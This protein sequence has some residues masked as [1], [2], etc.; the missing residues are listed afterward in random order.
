MD[1]IPVSS[2]DTVDRKVG[3][4]FKRAWLVRKWRDGHG[5]PKADDF[6]FERGFCPLVSEVVHPGDWIA[7]HKGELYLK[8]G[9]SEPSSEPPNHDGFDTR[10]IP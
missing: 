3:N 6:L 4:E 8:R 9:V 5:Y 7:R 1:F 10:R 2:S